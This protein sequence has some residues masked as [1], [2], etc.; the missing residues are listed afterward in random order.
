MA[1]AD[2]M[3]RTAC[4]RQ[5]RRSHVR[6]HA[7]ADGRAGRRTGSSL[8]TIPHWLRNLRVGQRF[9][10]L[11]AI[12]TALSLPL[13]G[14]LGHNLSQQADAARAERDG[15]TPLGAGLTLMRQTQLHR[16]LTGAWLNGNA[17]AGEQRQAAQS[18]VDRALQQLRSTVSA[19]DDAALNQTVQTLERDWAALRTAV[20]AR[21]LPPPQSFARHTALVARQRQLLAHIGDV[22]TLLLDPAPDGYYLVITVLETLPQ[23]S[24]SLGQA[25]A[26]GAAALARGQ[27][28]AGE[29]VRL[30]DL[31]A[32]MHQQREQLER[33]MMRIG[34]HD[35]ALQG[36]LQPRL[37]PALDALK[38]ADTTLQPL[39]QVAEGARPA[40]ESSAYFSTM[41]GHIEPLFA[42][43]DLSYTTLGARLQAR[44]D[45]M[46]T[47][48]AGTAAFMVACLALAAWLSWAMARAM[49]D[50][51]Q[52]VERL[53]TD[54]AAGRLDGR[55]RQTSE[56][57]LGQMVRTLAAASRQLGQV[58]GSV[59]ATGDEVGTAAAQIASG[60]DDLGG[61]SA[62][63]ASSLQQIA[64]SVQQLR[65]AVRT[66]ADHAAEAARQAAASHGV[67]GSGDALIA[68]VVQAMDE[69]GAQSRR[70][71]DI[72]GLID[73][74]AFQT[75]IL[76]LNAAV[77]A[78]RAGEAGRGFAVVAAEVRTLAQRSAQAAREIK[79][80]T[81]ASVEKVETGA[82]VVS[83]ARDTM[84]EMLRQAQQVSA[85]VE[86]IGQA[87]RQQS[88]EIEQTSQAL[89]LL[90]R[91][92]QQNVALVEE[93]TA[94]AD[95]L[96]R[97]AHDLRQ[98]VS[99]FEVLGD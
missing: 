30:A 49:R 46:H 66:N 71:A 67:A 77:E 2:W 13:A 34:Q 9:G 38:A 92:T 45:D 99:R 4:A 91:A 63:A 61:R 70:I 6:P 48:L 32:T 55:T 65:E 80:L 87:T 35:A 74:I 89:T 24:E 59:R 64:S 29:Q 14:L 23:L 69:L 10:L 54:L 43:A 97:Q 37:Q 25:R 36:A 93:S 90:D 42:L 62:Q 18:E 84:A 19:Y 21:E 58:L 16:G 27:I 47:Q 76:A 39:L 41:T 86:G 26:I 52:Q 60:V 68:Q 20:A 8:M 88:A 44:V 17:Q 57:E 83:S 81:A 50:N 73:G 85:L 95:S 22:S 5:Q 15:I 3:A 1:Q 72:T 51:L 28:G 75:N 7:R 78:A 33:Q 56:D 94:A 31:Q 98:T 53:S 82:R 12:G 11:V 40:G 79:S 96:N